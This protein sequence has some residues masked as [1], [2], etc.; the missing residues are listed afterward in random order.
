MSNPVTVEKLNL[1]G[2]V[3]LAYA[4]H[5]LER[6]ATRVV[7]EA[8]LTRG[9]MELGYVTLRP[10]DRLVEYFFTDRWY[11]VFAIYN[12]GDGAFKGWYCNVTRPA[13][14]VDTPY[15]RLVVRAVDLALDYF[16]QPGGAEYVLD[17][18]EFAALPLATEEAQTA[19]AALEELQGMAARGDL[20]QMR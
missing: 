13:E 16:R 6:T 12:V 4:G 2:E 14:L 15:G 10:G 20:Q 8:T 19:R 3:T 17:E 7:L 11:N 9:P 5:V 18:D 1:A